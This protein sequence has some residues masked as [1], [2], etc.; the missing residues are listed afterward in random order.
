MDCVL[1]QKWLPAFVR[2]CV[3][4]DME[5]IEWVIYG[6]VVDS[7]NSKYTIKDVSVVED[8]DSYWGG[9]GSQRKNGKKKY[10]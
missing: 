6:D 2:A 4:V 5:N 3:P 9:G 1:F 7:W 8:A 10:V